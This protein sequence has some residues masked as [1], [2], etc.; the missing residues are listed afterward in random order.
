MISPHR[1]VLVDRVVPQLKE[2]DTTLSNITLSRRSQSDL[3]MIAT[4]ACSPLMGF[5]S[6][7]ITPQWW[8]R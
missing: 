1:G 4:G 5:M 8:K 7:R 3:E 2:I 6:Q